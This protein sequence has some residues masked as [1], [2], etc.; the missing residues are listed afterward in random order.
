M[1]SVGHPA[2]VHLEL[3]DC[4]VVLGNTQRKGTHLWRYTQRDQANAM[5][6]PRRL[7]QSQ[8]HAASFRS[9]HARQK[10]RSVNQTRN[11]VPPRKVNRCPNP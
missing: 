1:K 11:N 4:L 6:L 7:T 3:E 10:D 8:K 9:T 5:P 2:R